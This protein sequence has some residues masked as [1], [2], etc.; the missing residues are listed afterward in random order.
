MV[1]TWISPIS[2]SR[3][4]G[5]RNRGFTAFAGLTDESVFLEPN[6][7]F[8]SRTLPGDSGS[9]QFVLGWIVSLTSMPDYQRLDIPAVREFLTP[10][11][12]HGFMRSRRQPGY[13]GK[14]KA[15]KRTR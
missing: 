14:R 3:F 9:P 10:Y 15:G 4:P 12:G 1:Q 8:I 6:E 13:P 5:Y 7:D 2:D 11:A